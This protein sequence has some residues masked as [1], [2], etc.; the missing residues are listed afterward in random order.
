LETLQGILNICPRCKFSN[1]EYY[2]LL[3][4]FKYTVMIIQTFQI[5]AAQGYTN[6]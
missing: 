2:Y 5:Y 6:N 3:E 1:A 4:F